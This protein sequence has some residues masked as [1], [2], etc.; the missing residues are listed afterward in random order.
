MGT[1]AGAL[2]GTGE[3]GPASVTSI[4]EILGKSICPRNA[5]EYMVYR[6]VPSQARHK[7]YAPLECCLKRQWSVLHRRQKRIGKFSLAP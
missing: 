4:A 3:V 2:T 6:A 5:R 7:T 1:F